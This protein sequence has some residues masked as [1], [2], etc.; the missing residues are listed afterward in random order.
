MLTEYLARLATQYVFERAKPFAGSE[1]ANFVR[2][3]IAV[4]ANKT[5]SL[6]V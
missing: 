1:F 4:E 5:I 3:N 2:H 6:G